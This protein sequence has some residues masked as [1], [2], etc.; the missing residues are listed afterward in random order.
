[1]SETVPKDNTVQHIYLLSD[2]TGETVERVVRA[3]LSQF[4]DVEIKLHRLNRLRT[5]E[6]VSEALSMVLQVRGIII[7]TLVNTELAQFLHDEAEANNLEAVD[8]ITPLL[9]KFSRF[10]GMLPQEKPG[11]LHQLNA[12]YH[13][14]VEAVNFAVKHDDGQ[15][16]RNL[17]K[18][19]LV[20]VGVSRTSKTPL[21]MYLANKGYK[22]ANIP[23]VKGIDPPRELFQI[24][25]H[26][27]IALIINAKR[28]VEL[29]SSRL[30]N[31][32][33]S[34]KGSYADYEN[35]E[36]ELE[37]CRQLFRS[38]PEWLLIDVTHK[39]IEETATEILKKQ[40][41]G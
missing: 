31:L 23:L 5:R 15:E 29:R 16:P 26:K 21:S 14:R 17:G 35:V 34:P 41:G 10:F 33:Q 1:M 8:L 20:L 11:L 25:Q 2:A 36:D 27:V 40:R 37:Y 22:V 7:Y 18:A 6:D 39:A 38:H 24:D 30:R 12:E 9:F 19:D 3:A 4:K 13:K 32:R 28:L